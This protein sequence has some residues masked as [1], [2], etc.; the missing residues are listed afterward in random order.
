VFYA[1]RKTDQIRS[2]QV[3]LEMPFEDL[4]LHKQTGNQADDCIITVGSSDFYF[5]KVCAGIKILLFGLLIFPIYRS[6]SATRPSS[7]RQ[8]KF[9]KP[10]SR[11]LRLVTSTSCC[12]G[13]TPKFLSLPW[14]E[15]QFKSIRVEWKKAILL[16]RFVYGQVKDFVSISFSVEVYKFAHEMEMKSLMTVLEKYFKDEANASDIFTVFDMYQTL[17]DN[18]GVAWCKKV[19]W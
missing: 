14:S 5:E 12:L 13:S 3:S 9:W 18:E 6:S 7:T 11:R 17:N 4:M 8:V 1:F 10:R 2:E 19:M 15:I 16:C